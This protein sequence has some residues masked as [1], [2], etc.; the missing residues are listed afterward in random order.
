MNLQ[1]TM[2]S[3][4]LTY[5]LARNSLS[6]KVHVD[7]AKLSHIR[8]FLCNQIAINLRILSRLQ[9]ET[10]FTLRGYIE[11][12]LI[13][14]IIHWFPLFFPACEWDVLSLDYHLNKWMDAGKCLPVHLW[15]VL[16]GCSVHYGHLQYVCVCLC[17]DR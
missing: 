2:F 15:S 1:S 9:P 8:H 17:I 7:K 3:S 10:F 5:L 12:R 14:W 4:C 11:S 16:M 13:V 6:Q